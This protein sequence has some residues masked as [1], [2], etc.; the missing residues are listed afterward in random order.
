MDSFSLL[1]P[2]QQTG[3][4]H[5]PSDEA[6]RRRNQTRQTLTMS[7]NAVS[8]ADCVASLRTSLQYLES[9]VSTI[10]AGVSDFP[11]LVTALKTVRVRPLLI[12]PHSPFAAQVERE[13]LTG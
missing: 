4:I 2:Y 9:S 6:T 10:D 3:P 1:T 11:R 5:I 12:P 13:R 8:Y 7:S